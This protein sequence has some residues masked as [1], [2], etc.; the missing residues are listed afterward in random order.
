M[1]WLYLLIAIV[2]E[3][4]G[5]TFMKLSDGLTRWLPTILMFVFYAGSLSCLT[6]ALKSIDVS[7]AYAVWSGVGTA[8]IVA[9]GIIAFGEPLTMARLL[10]IG[11]I[12][13]GAVGLNLQ[14][15]G[16]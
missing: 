13:A 15:G 12:I 11:L 4:T 2:L 7:V 16:H 10:L 1:S 5:T 14:G 9:V 6:M 8:L 3:V